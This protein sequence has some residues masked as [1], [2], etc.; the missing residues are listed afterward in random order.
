MSFVLS[1]NLEGKPQRHQARGGQPLRWNVLQFG[2]VPVLQCSACICSS[3]DWYSVVYGI[4]LLSSL[5]C[6]IMREKLN[7]YGL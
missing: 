6:S 7:A 1:F 3:V 2:G 4:G 5:S